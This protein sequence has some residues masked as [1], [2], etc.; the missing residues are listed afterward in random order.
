VELDGSGDVALLVEVGVLVDLADD[1]AVLA[2]MLGQPL[3]RDEDG[4]RLSVLR[5]AAPPGGLA[6][7]NEATV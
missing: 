4:V 7:E 3:G 6:S 5:H 1:E 2:E